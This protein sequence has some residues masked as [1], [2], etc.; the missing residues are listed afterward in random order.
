MTDHLFRVLKRLNFMFKIGTSC[1]DLMGVYFSRTFEKIQQL[2]IRT[3]VEFE[4]HCCLLG[5]ELLLFIG[6]KL[7]YC[8]ILANCKFVFHD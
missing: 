8:G 7:V 2:H 5:L 6:I 4:L 1:K 3:G